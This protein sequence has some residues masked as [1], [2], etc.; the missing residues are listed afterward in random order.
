[1]STAVAEPTTAEQLESALSEVKKLRGEV[2]ELRKAPSDGT[3]IDL[4]APPA[5]RKGENVMSS[6]PFRLRTAIGLACGKIPEERAK[7]EKAM[8]DGFRK[9]MFETRSHLADMSETNLY[10]PI[11]FTHL[12]DELRYTDIGLQLKSMIAEGAADSDPDEVEWIGRRIPQYGRNKTVMKAAL[13]GAQSAYDD[14]LGGTLIAPPT[15]GDIIPLMRN[16]SMLDRAG[17]Q[18]FP[19]PPS[20]KWVAPRQSGAT[21]AYWIT[22]ESITI[23]TSNVTTGQ[24]AMQAKKLGVAMV[25][26]NDLFKFTSGAADALFR[27]DI[28]KSLALKMDAAGIYG[29]GGGEPKGLKQYTGTNELINYAGIT[30]PYTPKGVGTNGNVLFPE[31]GENMLGLIEDRNFDT[32]TGFAWI[33]RGTLFRRL[34]SVR[35]DAVTAGDEKGPFVTALTRLLSQTNSTNWSGHKVVRSSQILN[36]FTKAGGSSLTEMYG[37]MWN[38]CLLATF[39]ALELATSP[40]ENAFLADQTIVRGI[41]YGDVGYR[42]PG[43]FVYY[44][45]LSTGSNPT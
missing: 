21:S 17:A 40:G 32:D 44:K 34:N 7:V 12:A 8:L 43:A 22:P 25:V 39:G 24:M 9:A 5:V 41:L 16:M 35:G 36:N 18:N 38:E 29:G 37:G 14:S 6:R 2:V 3:G 45:E 26:P 33:M 42:Y 4:T 11:G 23:T 15:Q 31:D 27:A 30:D 20:G 19:L 10:F 13:T 28:A 1:M